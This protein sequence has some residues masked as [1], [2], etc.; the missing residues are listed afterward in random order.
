MTD[1]SPALTNLEVPSEGDN[2][3]VFAEPWEARVF[4][5]VVEANKQGRFEWT[6]IPTTSSQRN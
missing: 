3:L 1:Y 4:A 6:R 2:E 5:L